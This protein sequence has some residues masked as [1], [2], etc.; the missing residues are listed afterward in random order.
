MGSGII[1]NCGEIEREAKVVPEGWAGNHKIKKREKR[2]YSEERRRRTR[3]VPRREATGRKC[4][5]WTANTPKSIYNKGPARW[6]EEGA[7]I[8]GKGRNGEGSRTKTRNSG[9]RALLRKTK[10]AEG[11][12]STRK[13]RSSRSAGSERE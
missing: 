9:R 7:V 6:G 4:K 10:S 11:S 5:G 3:T 8:I 13:N 2:D 1:L 12:D